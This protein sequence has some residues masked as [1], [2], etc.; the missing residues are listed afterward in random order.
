MS[1]NKSRSSLRSELFRARRLSAWPERRN[2]VRSEIIC[3]PRNTKSA[4]QR[5]SLLRSHGLLRKRKTCS[6]APIPR[7]LCLAPLLLRVF[8][9][10]SQPN[11]ESGRQR[12]AVSCCWRF[13]VILV[14]HS[15]GKRVPSKPFRQTPTSTPSRQLPSVWRGP[16][17]RAS[18]K[19]I[20]LRL[21]GLRVCNSEAS[22]D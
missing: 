11:V 22:G 6:K 1:G 19:R 16:S 7:Q 8:T 4:M 12:P 15:C 3:L 20:L 17:S 10:F 21:S 5:K 2:G 13:S 14:R 18:K 9:A